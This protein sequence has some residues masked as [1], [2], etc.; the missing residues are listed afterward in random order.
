M[1]VLKGTVNGWLDRSAD[2]QTNDAEIHEAAFLLVL[3]TYIDHDHTHSTYNGLSQNGC[4]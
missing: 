4:G 2:N 1:P 3:N